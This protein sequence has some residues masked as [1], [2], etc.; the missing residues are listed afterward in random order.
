MFTDELNPIRPIRRVML[1]R[2]AVLVV[3]CGLLPHS[4][5]AVTPNAMQALPG[6][7]SLSV[8]GAVP[9]SYEG[10]LRGQSPGVAYTSF[11]S[12]TVDDWLTPPT[13]AMPDTVFNR[14][15]PEVSNEY[16]YVGNQTP[17]TLLPSYTRLDY[18]GGSIKQRGE[19]QGLYA[20][21]SYGVRLLEASYD[22]TDIRFRSGFQLHQHDYTVKYT[23]YWTEGVGYSIGGHFIQSN[24]ITTDEV[25]IL[26]TGVQWYER[27]RWN[28]DLDF[29]V[30]RYE[31]FLPDITVF[32]LSGRF[33]RYRTKRDDYTVRTEMA[34]HYIHTSENIIGQSNLFSA[35]LLFSVDSGPLGVSLFGWAGQQVFPVRNG[36]FLVFNLGDER[37]GGYGAEIRAAFTRNGVLTARLNNEHVRDTFNNT[38][39]NQ[40]VASL[41][42][43]FT[44]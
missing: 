18:G 26:I 41:L 29:F 39:T 16:F 38:L 43:S 6:V 36:G 30:S 24:D 9:A 34:A 20:S 10:V 3:A 31:E 12:R 27:D 33:G 5:Q 14:S 15:S 1:P 8:A 35:E 13:T 7:S 40:L 28:A 44:F 2:L 22:E 11:P 17:I 4:A 37:L 19:L 23:D 21:L 42:Y 25:T 32:Q